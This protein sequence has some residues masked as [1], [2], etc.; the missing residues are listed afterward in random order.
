MRSLIISL[1]ADSDGSDDGVD[2]GPP[3]PR[4]T[5]K[6]WRMT[7]DDGDSEPNPSQ[8]RELPLFKSQ[9]LAVTA[10][11]VLD[12]L[13]QI[14]IGIEDGAVLLLRGDFGRD[15]GSIKQEVVRPPASDFHAQ[16]AEAVAGETRYCGWSPTPN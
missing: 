12:D 4:A 13:S 9:E 10:L 8:V 1:S 2:L 14:A 6:I 16:A 5:L 7:S 3:H 11:A 15:R